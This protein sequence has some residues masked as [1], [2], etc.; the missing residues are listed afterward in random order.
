MTYRVAIA[1]DE[2]QTEVSSQPSDREDLVVDCLV[3]RGVHVIC[4]DW[5]DA[6]V[7]WAQYDLVMPR[8]VWNY[9]KP[10]KT[11]KFRQ[12]LNTLDDQQ[13]NVMN[14]TKVIRWNMDKHYLRDLR[15]RGAPAPLSVYIDCE[16]DRRSLVDLMEDHGW[17]DVFVRPCVAA[18]SFWSLRVH[19]DTEKQ[20]SKGQEMIDYLLNVHHKDVVIQKYVTDIVEKG[21]W[22]LMFFNKRYSHA[23]NRI[24][25][26]GGSQGFLHG[27]DTRQMPVPENVKEV[28]REVMAAVQEP[29]L[30]ARVDMME[31]GSDVTLVELEVIEPSLFLGHDS[32]A[33]EKFAEAIMFQ[34]QKN[35][36]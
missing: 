6:S 27:F 17:V 18:D 12:W 5:E 7:N 3:E 2:G 23:V 25:V 24:S 14:S 35:T 34:L 4:C 13:A 30:Y 10:H 9:M 22:C 32:N 1:T 19:L 36:I 21:E 33:P 31:D 8:S 29:I 16:G 26:D 15:N 20:D 11:N 28:A